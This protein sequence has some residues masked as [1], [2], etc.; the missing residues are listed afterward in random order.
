MA[1]LHS[2]KSKTES[3]GSS[4]DGDASDDDEYDLYDYYNEG[5]CKLPNIVKNFV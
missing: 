2:Q 3:V 1:D 5:A 4:V